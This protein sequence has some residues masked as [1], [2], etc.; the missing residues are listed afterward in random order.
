MVVL[1]GIALIHLIDVPD[2]MDET[3]WQGWLFIGLM[4]GCVAAAGLLL[5]ART[6]AAWLLG[7]GLAAATIAAYCLSR[8][9][10]LLGANDDIGNWSEG[11]GLA[12][13]Y[14]EAVMV[15]LTAYALLPAR[16]TN[17]DQQLTSA[18]TP[19]VS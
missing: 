11:L 15:L 18:T 9:T 17:R 6:S 4:V 8:T 7:G 2:K 10:G 19:A 3:P 5:S 1:G 14:V 13:L 12:S 16:A